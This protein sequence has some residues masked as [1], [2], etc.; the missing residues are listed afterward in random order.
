MSVVNIY[1]RGIYRTVVLLVPKDT[2][3]KLS[4]DNML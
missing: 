1:D 2:E 4:Y 3:V